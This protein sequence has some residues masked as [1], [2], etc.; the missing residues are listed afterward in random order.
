M[1]SVR[2]YCWSAGHGGPA[3]RTT[4]LPSVSAPAGGTCRAE[5]NRPARPR[6]PAAGPGD[7]VARPD[8]HRR[9]RRSGDRRAVGRR[10]ARPQC[11]IV[12]RLKSAR[13]EVRPG[14]HGSDDHR[15]LRRRRPKPAVGGGRHRARRAPQ[16]FSQCGAGA[17]GVDGVADGGTCLRQPG[18]QDRSDHRRRHRR[19]TTAPRSTRRGCRVSWCTTATGS[20]CA[21]AET[22]RSTGR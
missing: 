6:R 1:R 22:P 9:L 20:P 13:A 14:R 18:R 3:T 7:R 21:M 12:K 8:R 17:V 2:A 5:R 16:E 19:E 11:R 15:N 10:D 4:Q